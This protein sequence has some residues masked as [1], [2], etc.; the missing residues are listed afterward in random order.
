MI[1]VI[2]LVNFDNAKRIAYLE[3]S[4]G[5][6]YKWNASVRHLVFDGSRAVDAQSSLYKKFGVEVVHCPSATFGERLKI[7]MT[8][9]QSDYFL[10]LPDDFHWIFPFPIEKACEEGRKFGIHEIKLTCRGME[11][12]AQPGANPVPWFTGAQVMSGEKLNREG[13]LFV[14]RRWIWRDFHEQ[15]SLA[16]NLLQT[17][18]ARWVVDRISAKVMSPGQAEKQAYVWLLLRK[19]AVAYYRMWIPAFHF[20]DL[21]VEGENAQNKLK[22][23]TQLVEANFETYNRNYNR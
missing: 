9:V 15:F 19:Y 22:A 23:S 12:F 4:F 1:D 8:M 16:C 21:R 7:A 6:F 14:S 17:E 18:F 11:W 10:F 2:S 20:M 3:R 13:E 5:S